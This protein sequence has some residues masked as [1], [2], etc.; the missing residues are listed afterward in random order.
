MWPDV[1]HKRN[2]F[3]IWAH[4]KHI[5]LT[6]QA[7]LGTPAG[8]RRPPAHQLVGTGKG[9]GSRELWFSPS[10]LSCVLHGLG[11]LGLFPGERTCPTEHCPQACPKAMNCS[12]TLPSGLRS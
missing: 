11:P 4:S 2:G 6:V 12:A 7:W 8:Q 1:A 9:Q 3:Y 10:R 5:L